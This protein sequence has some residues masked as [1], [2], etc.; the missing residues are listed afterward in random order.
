MITEQTVNHTMLRIRSTKPYYITVITTRSYVINGVAIYDTDQ[1][2]SYSLAWPD[3]LFFLLWGSQKE[4]IA[5]WLRETTTVGGN[6][7]SFDY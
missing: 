3:H 5:V 7:L 2:Q 6:S 4:K 1:L